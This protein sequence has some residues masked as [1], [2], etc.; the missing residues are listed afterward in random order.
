MTSEV[1][2]FL[3]ENNHSAAEEAQVASSIATFISSMNV[4]AS[5]GGQLKSGR[6]MILTS[7]GTTAPLEENAVRFITNFSSGSRGSALAEALLADESCYVIFVHAKSSRIPF[8][9][10][11][12]ALSLDTLASMILNEGDSA[13]AERARADMQ[14]YQRCRRRL[15]CISF[16]TVLSYISVLR[17]ACQVAG[18]SCRAGGIAQA[19]IVLA[20]AVSDYYCPAAALA[21]HKISGGNG[22]DLHLQCVPKALGCLRLWFGGS[23]SPSSFSLAA[24]KVVSFKLET[25]ANEIERKA[26]SNLREYTCDAVVANLL[27]SYQKEVTVYFGNNAGAPVRPPAALRLGVDGVSDLDAAIARQLLTL[28]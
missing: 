28:W 21:K 12:D 6:L 19:M 11:L 23:P 13:E 20:A 9:R 10:S 3:L 8:R 27:Q 16:D 24:L 1:D 15:L 14:R 18:A 4:L 22:L 17:T 25:D 26:T 5:D 2:A 7:G